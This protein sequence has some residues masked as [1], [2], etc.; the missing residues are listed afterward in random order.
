MMGLNFSPT[1]TYL[2]NGYR[3]TLDSHAKTQY[4]WANT[5]EI[6]ILASEKVGMK[7]WNVHIVKQRIATGC[8]SATIVGERSNR[9]QLLLRVPGAA[10]ILARLRPVRVCRGA[11]TS[12]EKYLDRAA[13]ARRCWLTTSA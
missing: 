1:I 7:L 4:T 11:A 6:H 10:E 5:V 12:S 3:K 2:L 9:L 13:W 8:A